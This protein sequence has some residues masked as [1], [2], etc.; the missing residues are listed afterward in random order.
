[1]TIRPELLSYRTLIYRT[2][3]HTAFIIYYRPRIVSI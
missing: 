1:M 3:I 2:Q